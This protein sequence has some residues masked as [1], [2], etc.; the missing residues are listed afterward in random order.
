MTNNS[1]FET[2][3]QA[4]QDQVNKVIAGMTDFIF[5]KQ[6]E[7]NQK[8]LDQIKQAKP[9]MQMIKLDSDERAAFKQASMPMRDK[10]IELTG[11]SGKAVLSS[12]E[13]EFNQ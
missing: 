7:F 13:Q 11:D 6:D 8:R 3:P 2:L 5:E 12:L 10:Y 9:D 4:R 1:W